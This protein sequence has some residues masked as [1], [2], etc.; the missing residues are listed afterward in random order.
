M[1]LTPLEQ[2]LHLL[3]FCQ[4]PTIVPRFIGFK[5]KHYECINCCKKF[6]LPK[7]EDMITTRKIA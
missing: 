5:D 3:G 4:H 7:D 2:L 6:Y 1:Y